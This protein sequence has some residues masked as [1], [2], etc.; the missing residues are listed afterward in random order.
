MHLI[1]EM[2]AEETEEDSSGEDLGAG[3]RE[4]FEQPRDCLH[5]ALCSSLR[6]ST[7]LRGLYR[8]PGSRSDLLEQNRA[9]ETHMLSA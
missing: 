2:V 9:L 6:S 8:A 3:N 5:R 4:H 7:S 1:V